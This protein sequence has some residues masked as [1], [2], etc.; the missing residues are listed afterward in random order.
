MLAVCV[1]IAVTTSALAIAAQ[2]GAP[3]QPQPG[4][5]NAP[6]VTAF[7]DRVN[8]YVALH[9]RL[10]KTAPKLPD[11]ATPK[12]IDDRQRALLA[13]IQKARPEAKRGDLFTPEMTAFAKG[14]LNR[15]FAG[16]DGK[17]LLSS[18]MDENPVDIAL[19]VNQRYPDSVPFATMPPEVLM[20]LPDLPEELEY[21][22]IGDDLI[23][24]DPHAHIVVDFIPDALPGR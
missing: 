5:G 3:P 11:A 22:F 15:V 4:A 23:L 10:E 14:M 2:R 21:R 9:Q 7:V 13:L 16:P 19:K 20:A 6:A 24:L 18:I 8:A 17:Q 12:Q 1:V